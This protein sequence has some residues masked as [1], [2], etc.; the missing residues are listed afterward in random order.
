MSWCIHHLQN[1]ACDDNRTFLHHGV[2][3]GSE[4]VLSAA[5]SD[6]CTVPR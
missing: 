4:H 2:Q 5:I 6:S 1:G 3:N